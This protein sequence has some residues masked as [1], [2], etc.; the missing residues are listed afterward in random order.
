[1]NW[2]PIKEITCNYKTYSSL[3]AYTLILGANKVK[4]RGLYGF[5]NF[6]TFIMQK[7]ANNHIVEF[8]T[9]INKMTN[10]TRAALVHLACLMVKHKINQLHPPFFL[11]TAS[12]IVCFNVIICF[13]T[14]CVRHNNIG[15]IIVS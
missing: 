3:M 1:M 8:P 4:K 14:V 10:H 7:H 13:F 12:L 11:I 9:V 6:L 2:I 15:K 5:S